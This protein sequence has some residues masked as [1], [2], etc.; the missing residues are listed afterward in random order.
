VW[1]AWWKASIK[2]SAEGQE[3]AQYNAHESD[4]EMSKSCS[5]CAQF[6]AVAARAEATPGCT[7]ELMTTGDFMEHA[8]KTMMSQLEERIGGSAHQMAFLM[9]LRYLSPQ[10]TSLITEAVCWLGRI[11]PTFTRFTEVIC[12]LLLYML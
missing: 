6:R 12:Y 4:I 11:K 8:E 9:R 2:K 1:S 7:E 5:I 3:T 10:H